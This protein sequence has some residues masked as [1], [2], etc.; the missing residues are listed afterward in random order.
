MSNEIQEFQTI[1]LDEKKKSIISTI[2]EEQ[3]SNPDAFNGTVETLVVC[4]IDSKMSLIF[5]PAPASHGILSTDFI[6]DLS[7]QLVDLKRSMVDPEFG[8]WFSTTIM[9]D[10][11][12]LS[13]LFTFN[14][15]DDVNDL[16]PFD[17]MLFL[18][19]I[20]RYPRKEENV[21]LWFRKRVANARKEKGES[22]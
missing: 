8:A 22:H 17:D 3:A 12:T 21:P 16:A 10:D 15:E 7:I 2:R 9:L 4:L 18:N 19:E 14:Y 1:K 20:K 13:H 5:N 6:N 11:K